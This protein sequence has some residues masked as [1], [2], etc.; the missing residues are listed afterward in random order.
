MHNSLTKRPDIDA[1]QHFIIDFQITRMILNE[2]L[3]FRNKLKPFS[4]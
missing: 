3:V 2:C 4:E 1:A